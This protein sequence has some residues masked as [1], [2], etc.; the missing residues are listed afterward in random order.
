M[1]VFRLLAISAGLPLWLLPASPAPEVSTRLH[2]PLRFE[3]TADGKLAA[4]EGPFR[5]L[6]ETGRTTITVAD[7]KGKTASVVT[8]LAGG[9]PSA[10]P[11]G[12][13]AF[14]ARANYLIGSDPAQWRTNVPFY[15]R[16]IYRGIYPGVD[17]VFH[18]AGDALEYDFVVQPG[19]SP[20]P[21]ALD[22]SGAE[23]LRV[24]ADGSLVIATSAG[25]IRWKKPEVYQ[26]LDG[27]RRRVDGAFAL[28]GRRVTFRL[29]AYDR[30]RQ[31][32][33]DPTLV[34]A[35][36]QGG[37]LNDSS[38]AVAVDSNGNIYIAGYAFSMNLPHTGGS[39]QPSYKGGSASGDYGG[40]AFVAKYNSSGSII[41]VT[42]LGGSGDDIAAGIAVDSS[43][44]AYVT[45]VTMSTDF[46][47]TAGAFQT[48]FGGSNPNDYS[49]A[50]GDAFVTK[51]NSTGTVLMYS[52][53]LGGNSSDIGAAIAVDSAGNAYIG[54]STLSTNFPIQNAA[55]AT[56][57]G[58]GGNPPL[59]SG[60][61][62]PLINSGDG[63]V[64]KLNPGGTALLWSTYVGGS[65]DDSVMALALDSS[66]AVYVGGA[67][68][69]S[70]FPT[71][72]AFQSKYG[73]T[74][75][76][77]VQP[78]I[79]MGDGFV[80]KYDANGNMVYSTYIGG[81]GDDAVQGIAVDSSGAAYVA[82]FTSSANLA[83]A[84]V[85]YGSFH[86][87]A[88]LTGQRGFVWGDAFAAKLA[89]SGSSLVYAIYVGGS[90]DDAAFAIAVDGSGEAIIGGFA[91]STD[92]Q[93]SPDAIQSKFGGTR[94]GQFFT[95]DTGDAFLAKIRAD[96][97]AVLYNSYYG[98]S[99]DDAITGLAIGSNNNVVAVGSTTSRNLPVTSNAAQ[100]NF[101]GEDP[102]TTTEVLGDAFMAIFSGIASSS[103]TSV[104]AIVNGATLTA[105]IAPGTAVDVFG[106]NLPASA[107]AGAQILGQ[108]L[109]VIYASTTQ[110]SVIIPSTLAPGT[111]T[112]QIGTN[113]IPI[114]L[115][116]YAPGLFSLGNT[117]AVVAL[118]GNAAVSSTNP[119]LPGDAITLDATG[120]GATNA[121]GAV[122]APV[123]VTLGSAQITASSVTAAASSPGTYNVTFTVP[124][125]TAAGN[126]KVSI[127]IG[128]QT[129]N[130]LTLPVGSVVS[131]GP[132]ITAVQN[133][134]SFVNGSFP[135]NAYMTIVG[136]NLA[137]PG[138]ADVWS[139]FIVNGNLPTQFDGVSVTVGG[140]P[141]YVE[142]VSP[143][144]INV[145]APN[146]APG[147]V[148]VVVKNSLGVSPAFQAN[149]AAY[150]PAFFQYT[151]PGTSSVYAI[152]THLD[153]TYAIPGAVPAKPGEVIILWG[154]GF[155]P[156]TPPMPVGVELPPTGFSAA[157]LPTV[158][159]GGQNANV[160]AAAM[161]PGYASLYQVAVT[162]PAGLAN[163]DYPIVATVGGASSPST[164]LLSVHQ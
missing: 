3:S 155:G 60:C 2:L 92:M 128:G 105:P 51:L 7:G 148:S 145:V 162:V 76:A 151:P 134:A 12:D 108:S 32:V 70:N 80:T 137:A 91:N 164:V 29:G 37:S 15:R 43:G 5:L 119:A 57:G 82:G 116:Q 114:T 34:Y 161:A 126:P 30:S 89:P 6:V 27:A 143:G 17:L 25:D 154:M 124:A 19:A 74:L 50:S 140:Q 64:A 28:R 159:I 58:T 65:F 152:A 46:P 123:T 147:P 54:G 133:G 38:R 131:I 146:I 59:C 9:D 101:G 21:I 100:A 111:Y 99:F 45:G 67:T 26:T 142:Y 83:P 48:K 22:I 157:T 104:S 118:K 98:G 62:G 68:L 117:G 63:F 130:A 56:F 47:T 115:V 150:Q 129:S 69:S 163:G 113:N 78:V 103:T 122:T 39:Y 81:S 61:H 121:A 8:T 40:D 85:L 158:T 49:G 156:T 139:N 112:L 90:Q 132:T 44:N 35:T 4:Q 87:P 52:T 96:G 84:S 72:N 88:A 23:G 107:S 1:R 42:Y 33:I 36:Y 141:A 41:Y 13:D 53:Y 144:Q 18:G 149:A 125:G 95:D 79:L 136:N 106:S 11:S 135:V 86:G 97:T 20:K 120:L 73:G 31:L 93:L 75:G 16:A 138:V 77:N 14:D 109:T 94:A 160:I 24:D 127:T 71:K 10:H 153:F 110:W 102:N 66:N 55:Q